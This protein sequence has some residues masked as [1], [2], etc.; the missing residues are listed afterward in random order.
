[1]ILGPG[2][3]KGVV[4]KAIETLDFHTTQKYFFQDRKLYA[5]AYKPL[6]PEKQ[7]QPQPENSE[8]LLKNKVKSV[9]VNLENRQ[10]KKASTP[11]KATP[12]SKEKLASATIPQ[13]AK[14][15][16]GLAS[17]AVDRTIKK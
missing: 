6:S 4:L 14:H 5:K 8:D 9:V 15:K 11:V 2:P 1:M 3:D 7:L 16:Q 10:E 12:T 13:V 17:G